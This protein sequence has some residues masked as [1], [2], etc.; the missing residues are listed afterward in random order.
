MPGKYYVELERDLLEAEA[1]IDALREKLGD[2]L[3]RID[4]LTILLTKGNDNGDS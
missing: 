2:A 1:T 3:L 4:E